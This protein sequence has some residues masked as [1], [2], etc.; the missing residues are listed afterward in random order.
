MLATVLGFPQVLIGRGLTTTTAEGVAE[1]SVVYARIWGKH[2]L[3]CY[4]PDAPSLRRPAGGYTFVWGGAQNVVS[5]APQYIKTMRDE[6]REVDII[7]GNSYYDMK[8]TA[9]RAGLFMS[10]A[11]A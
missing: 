10:G 1:A 4:V 5:G 3:M 6:E 8:I 7:E 11:I 2:A 9:A